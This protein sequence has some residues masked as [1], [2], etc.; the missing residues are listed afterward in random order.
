MKIA[1][2]IKFRPEIESGKYKVVSGN[3]SPVT[4]LKWDAP[5]KEYP[6]I[7]MFENGFVTN[8]SIYGKDSD[9]S[10]SDLYIIKED[11]DTV[12]EL[13]EYLK[14]FNPDAKVCIGDTFSGKLDVGWS[15][16]DGC[17]K[18]DCMYVC[19]DEKGKEEKK[20]PVPPCKPEII[21]EDFDPECPAFGTANFEFGLRN[22]FADVAAHIELKQNE[23]E[24]NE[25]ADRLAK[26]YAPK[27]L[28]IARKE[29][30][31]DRF[32]IE[33]EAMRLMDIDLSEFDKFLCEV[34]ESYVDLECP[35][36]AT[37]IQGYSKKILEQAM[38]AIMTPKYNPDGG[39]ELGDFEQNFINLLVSWRHGEDIKRENFPQAMRD[40]QFLLELAKKRF[41][42]EQ[43]ALNNLPMWIRVKNPS[44]SEKKFMNEGFLGGATE[45]RGLYYKGYKILLSELEKLPKEPEEEE[46]N[47]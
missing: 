27:L 16:G 45:S 24:M 17:T 5:C 6:I 7:G 18:Q 21:K 9:S 38:L 22:T 30:A 40:S 11:I 32:R 39:E 25:E 43:V 4:I 35:I 26:L 33:Q 34:L 31:Y 44:S 42:K 1:F 14:E 20:N 15:G 23:D 3:L 46:N 8:Y 28:K 10:Y 29:I 13:I 12:S 47:N 36:P 37:F 2:D 19:F 41:E